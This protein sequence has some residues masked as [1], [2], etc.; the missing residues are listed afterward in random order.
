MRNWMLQNWMQHSATGV[1]VVLMCL[2]SHL[3]CL[4]QIDQCANVARLNRKLSG[5]VDDYTRNHGHFARVPSEILGRRQDLYVYT[6]PGYCRSKQYPLVIW[7]H[8]AFGDEHAFFKS[9]QL[10]YL[11]EQIRCGHLPPMLVACPDGTLTGRNFVLTK[12]SFYVNGIDGCYFD[13]LLQEIVPF[14]TSN[15]SVS[16]CRH[17]HAVV[18]VSAGGMG[19]MNYALACPDFIGSVAV[20]SGALNLRYFSCTGNYGDDFNPSTY[21]WRTVWEPNGPIGKMGPI[22]IKAKTF[23]S[24]VFG[25]DE[26]T[27]ERIRVNNPA[28]R[29]CQSA[30]AVGKVKMLVTYGEQDEFNFDAQ[31]ESFIYFARGHG[32]DVDVMTD[33]QGKHNSDFFRPMQRRIYHWLG[34]KFCEPCAESEK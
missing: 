33:P 19:A 18:G 17:Q 7:L 31:A 9:A 8:G 24:P 29:L 23:I 34:D 1:L 20:L 28:D 32:F 5:R 16:P 15:Y 30:D 22:S 26:H 27:V 11:D 10:E 2:T 6:P 13:N 3:Q 12:H 14:V 25:N 21:R 4:A